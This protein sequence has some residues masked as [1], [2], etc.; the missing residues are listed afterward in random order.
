MPIPSVCPVWVTARGHVRNTVIHSSALRKPSQH[1][2]PLPKGGGFK[3]FADDDNTLPVW[4]QTAG[5]DTRFLGKYVNGYGVHDPTYGPSGWTDWQATS[6]RPRTPL[7][8]RR[9]TTTAS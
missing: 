4:L 5:D 6:T 1:A 3:A 8:S 7:K 9:S 2:S